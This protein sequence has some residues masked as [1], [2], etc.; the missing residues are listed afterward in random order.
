MAPFSTK[1]STLLLFMLHAA[2]AYRFESELP[3][4]DSAS[5]PSQQSEAQSQ[6]G[7]RERSSSSREQ[8]RERSS[9]ARP[10]Q[11]SP[12]RP[13]S[14]QSFSPA[15]R[16]GSPS[17]QSSPSLQNYTMTN[18]VAKGAFGRVY[19]ATRRGNSSK[20]LKA[21]KVVSAQK[22]RSE[23]D[24][25]MALKL[26]FV[27]DVEGKFTQNGEVFLVT[28]YYEG[29]DL[30]MYVKQRQGIMYDPG[31][32]KLWGSQMAYGLWQLHRNRILYGDLKVENTFITKKKSGNV[33]LA[34]FGLVTRP[35]PTLGSKSWACETRRKGTLE[36]MAPSIFKQRPYGFEVD[37]W[38]F[39]VALFVMETGGCFSL[40][41]LICSSG[42]QVANM[43]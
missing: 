14:P 8:S 43:F 33:V 1:R 26:P 29:N 42:N 2:D 30:D 31:L 24:E 11:A 38:A 4:S 23:E 36:Y 22:Y 39:G 32:L 17:T 37:W 3:L 35:C 25:V 7:K 6:A 20:Q 9:S 19:L 21:V 10:V 40:W 5:S 16:L 41:F 15:Q 13:A 18:E 34:D 28:R 12:T 27:A